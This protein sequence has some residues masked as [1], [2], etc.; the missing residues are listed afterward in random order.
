MAQ[1]GNQSR[2]IFNTSKGVASSTESALALY[3][4]LFA[5]FCKKVFSK[6]TDTPTSDDVPAANT[7]NV[8][9]VHKPYK[10]S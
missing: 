6:N 5:W 4:L 2:Q 10:M 9:G 7:N 8:N 3:P 1:F